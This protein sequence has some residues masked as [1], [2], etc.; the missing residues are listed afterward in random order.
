[1]ENETPDETYG[2]QALSQIK[3]NDKKDLADGRFDDFII[4]IIVIMEITS[5][6]GFAPTGGQS[7]PFHQ[8]P[9][10]PEALV[11]GKD[12]VFIMVLPQ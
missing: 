9:D 7:R 10:I 8:V 12:L 4:L 6:P 11:Q 1:V 5:I 3:Y 2:L